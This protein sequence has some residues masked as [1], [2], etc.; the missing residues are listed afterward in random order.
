MSS[1]QGAFT[2][3][4][5]GQEEERAWNAQCLKKSTRHR[6]SDPS[7]VGLGLLSSGRPRSPAGKGGALSSNV[8]ASSVKTAPHGAGGGTAF[9]IGSLSTM[10]GGWKAACER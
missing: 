6:F 5:D 7:I 8:A 1:G 2:R 4:A 9:M 3:E 10:V